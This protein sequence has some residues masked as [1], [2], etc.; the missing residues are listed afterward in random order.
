[1]SE[2]NR[3]Y[4]YYFKCFFAGIFPCGITHTLLTPLDIYKCRKQVNPGMYNSLIQGIKQ[5]YS[6]EGIKGLYKGYQ[7]TIIG[8]ALQGSTKFGFYEI[9]KEKIEIKNRTLKFLLSSCLAELIA[10]FFLC[11][12]ESLKVRMQTSKGFT[13][14][15]GQGFLEIYKNEGIHG[16]YKGIIPLITRQ[17][18]NTMIKF[19]TFEN[20]VSFF[21]NKL[22]TKH[23]DQYTKGIKLTITFLSGYISGIFCCVVSNPADTIISKFNQNKTSSKVGL[24]NSIR[25]IYNE[26]GFF[27]L[28]RGLSTRILMTGTLSALEWLIYDYLKL[29]VGLETTGEK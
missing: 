29:I 2:K 4:N 7:P 6:Y 15:F 18:P 19:V 5:I 28:W 10:D 24:I 27:G 3:N 26:I 22:F 21:Y 13:N 8:Y 1:M 23:K 17:V 14:L 9:F 25:D 11:P 20:T 12:W 16:F